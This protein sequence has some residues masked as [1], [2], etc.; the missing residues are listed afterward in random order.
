[1]SFS[2]MGQV[3]TVRH[4]IHPKNSATRGT[5]GTVDKHRGHRTRKTIL[6]AGRSFGFAKQAMRPSL[7]SQVARGVRGFFARGNR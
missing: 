3:G 4:R 2:M 6:D 1:M 7:L 5:R